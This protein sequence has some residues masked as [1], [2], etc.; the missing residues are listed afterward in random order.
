MLAAQTDILNNA[1]W[2]LFERYDSGKQHSAAQ[3]KATEDVLKGLNIGGNSALAALYKRI[4]ELN[5]LG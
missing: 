4:R 2:S 5:G 1:F 3:K